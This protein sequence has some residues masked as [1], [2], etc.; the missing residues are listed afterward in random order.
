MYPIFSGPFQIITKAIATLKDEGGWKKST[1][2]VLS[3]IG[4]FVCFV[5]IRCW[6][7]V[8]TYTHMISVGHIF[9]SDTS[10][11][12]FVSAE[13][14]LQMY[15]GFVIYDN[16]D[17]KHKMTRSCTF[18]YGKRKKN[19]GV[20]TAS[21]FTL[22]R[23]ND[24][25]GA[26][27]VSDTDENNKIPLKD[28][29]NVS[30][31]CHSF[32]SGSEQLI[33][34]CPLQFDSEDIAYTSGTQHTV[35]YIRAFD[36]DNV[37]E[38]PDYQY[39]KKRIPRPF[40]EKESGRLI[41]SYVCLISDSTNHEATLGH[42]VDND[43]SWLEKAYYQF[44]QIIKCHDLSRCNY[45][46]STISHGVDVVNLRFA[47]HENAEIISGIAKVGKNY[48]EV[49]YQGDSDAKEGANFI[50]F[51]AILLESENAQMIRMFFITTLCAACF[52]FFMKYLIQILM[53][54]KIT[55]SKDN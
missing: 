27:L 20:N 37:L 48:V 38:S 28:V 2:L 40:Y 5:I 35:Y 33:E 15:D 25:I 55:T 1:R 12:H 21:D 51:T 26:P 45:I 42:S 53:S 11:T 44:R 31:F 36:D 41:H 17:N 6:T 49:S 16:K 46:I 24:Y 14:E 43:N 23:I 39:L 4:T 22:K 9:S 3:G 29:G 34:G 10:D 47:L 32:N 30:V 8:P 18:R 7:Y 54:I 50:T 52:G 13:V 19:P